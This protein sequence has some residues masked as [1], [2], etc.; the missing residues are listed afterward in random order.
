QRAQAQAP[1]TAPTLPPVVVEGARSPDPRTATEEEAREEIR[2]A[3]GGVELIPEERIE[4]SRAAN[5]KDV[6]EFTPGVLVRPRVGAA[7]ESQLSIRGSGLRNNFHLRGVSILIDGFP[8]GNAD[9]FSDFESL[10]LLNARRVEVYKGAGALR[11]GG[12]TL[13]GAINLVT[14]TGYDAGLLELRSEAG[15]FGFLK[16]HLAT[17]QVYGPLDLYLGLSDVELDGYREYAEQTRRRAYGTVGYALPGGATLRVDL[18]FVRS[19]ENL[20]GALTRQELDR[21]PRQADPENVRQRAARDYD[22]TRGAFTLRTPLGATQTLEWATQLNYQDLDHPLAFGIIDDTTYSWS[23]EL[24]WI[25]DAP[26]MGL[27]HRL[28]AGLQYFST[29]QIDVNFANVAGERGARTK[30]QVNLATNYAA[31]AEDQLDLTPA[32]TVVLGA[33]G[34]YATR[35]VRDRF[36]RDAPGDVDANDSDSVDFLSLSPRA[37]FVWRVA[38]AV[39]VF[40]SASHAYEP[41]LILELTAPGQPQGDLGQLAAQKAWQFE[42]G[43]RGAWGRLAWDLAVYDIELWDEIQNVNVQPFPGAPFTIPRFRNIDRSRHTGV[44][45]G[46]DLLL[47]ED[48]AP[49]LGLGTAG[50]SLRAR[51]AYTWSRFVFV[52]DV[53]FGDNDLPGAPRHFVA[54]ELRYDHR[55]GFWLAPGVEVVPHGY[56]VDSANTV[57]TQAYTVFNVRAGFDHRPWNLGFFVEARNLTDETYASSVVVDAANGRFFE[58]GDGRAFYAGVQW[59]W[60]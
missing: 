56:F 50:D 15:S 48:V 10:E 25:L 53:N 2:R 41:P 55:S 39:Q 42:V 4:E 36:L 45:V 23:S 60:R 8:Y 12:F 35:S 27:G 7:D 3:P 32:F 29:R 17:G 44:E 22:Y 51:A 34:Q 1:P 59:R 16:N 31:Y 18:G 20:P 54:A 57:R 13:G 21:T 9:G 19:E 38:P 52:D 40:G 6:L 49:R 43:T 14:K 47:L 46:L 24:R 33:R 37:G 28:V 58:P 26:L 30:D 5:L 11:Y